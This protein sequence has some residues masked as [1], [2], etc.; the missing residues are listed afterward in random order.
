MFYVLVYARF[1][2]VTTFKSLN[3]PVVSGGTSSSTTTGVYGE[4]ELELTHNHEPTFSYFSN[5]A[6]A[7]MSF[8]S[9]QHEV[10][11][12]NDNFIFVSVTISS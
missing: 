6:I 8:M 7:S 12:L 9:S 4:T 3:C 11:Q 2:N 5:Q 10:K 1:D